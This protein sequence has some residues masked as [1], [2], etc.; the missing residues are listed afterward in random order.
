MQVDDE[1][2]EIALEG[3]GAEIAKIRDRVTRLQERLR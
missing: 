1:M 3:S 2:R